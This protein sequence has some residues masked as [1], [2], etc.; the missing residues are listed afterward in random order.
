MVDVQAAVIR[1][2]LAGYARADECIEHERA[3][4]LARLTPEDAR[5]IWDDLVASWR[6][7]PAEAA[8]LERLTLWRVETKIT[9][10]HAF[11]Q[12]ARAKGLLL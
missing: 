6:P 12:M 5:R 11:E 8:S 1:E 7:T 2:I 3:D 10:R 4:R 9:M